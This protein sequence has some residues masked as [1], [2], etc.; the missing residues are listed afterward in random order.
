[1]AIVGIKDRK[2]MVKD[3]TS[4]AVLSAD[5]TALREYKEKKAMISASKETNEQI[6]NV[7]TKLKEIDDLK[8]DIFEIK[9]LLKGLI[10]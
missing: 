5:K 3:T 2:N 8:K 1:M 10:R 4:G 9:Q 6:N 7:M